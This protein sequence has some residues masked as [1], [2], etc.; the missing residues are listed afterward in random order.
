MHIQAV[1][2]RQDKVEILL[3]ATDD[4]IL[5]QGQQPVAAGSKRTRSDDPTPNGLLPPPPLKRIKT[6]DNPF[7]PPAAAHH[8]M[9]ASARLESLHPSGSN[10]SA[11]NVLSSAHSHGP[12]LASPVLGPGH[13][14]SL[15]IASN[16]FTVQPSDPFTG[17]PSNSYAS[18][19][20]ASYHAQ[21]NGGIKDINATQDQLQAHFAA[22]SQFAASQASAAQQYP[23]PSP[24]HMQSALQYPGMPH[25]GFPPAYPHMHPAYA[26][27]AAYAAYA[28][29]LVSAGSYP[30]PAMHMQHHHGVHMPN[31][32][33][34][35]PAS[36][37]SSA[38]EVPP[39]PPP[40]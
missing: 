31:P 39:P 35:A 36:L 28:A 40:Y 16:P 22:A 9:T 10:S 27:H 1:L 4:G 32:Y 5:L 29:R 25:P 20:G 33:Q 7:L 26:N 21:P 34:Y 15:P 23:P 2:T 24:F 13:T 14:D 17:Q 3:A 37:P 11:F 12:Y 18:Q 8:Q 30:N 19:S 38:L 6:T